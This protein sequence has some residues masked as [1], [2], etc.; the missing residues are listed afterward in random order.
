DASG[1]EAA[2]A[3]LL[4]QLTKCDVVVLSKFGKLEAARSGL[5]TAF[6]AVI[7]AGT[8]L[9]TSVSNKHREAWKAFAP[10]A[11]ELPAE[12]AALQRW[13]HDLA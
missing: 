12:A 10:A 5:V 4:G 1:I 6:Q 2:C 3:E 13:Q 8:P 11:I 7:D 9:L